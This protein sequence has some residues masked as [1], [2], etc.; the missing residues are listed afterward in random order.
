L[1]PIDPGGEMVTPE[2]PCTVFGLALNVGHKLDRL[3]Q[4]HSERAI[5]LMAADVS[6]RD[7]TGPAASCVFEQM[8]LGGVSVRTRLKATT[9]SHE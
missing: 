3:T 4:R 1:R 5:L 9:H 8:L 7:G 2:L 6:R